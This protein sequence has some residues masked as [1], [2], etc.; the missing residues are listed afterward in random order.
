MFF[1][2]EHVI[3]AGKNGQLC[4]FMIQF[5]RQVSFLYRN[6][7]VAVTVDNQQ[8]SFQTCYGFRKIILSGVGEKA[9]VRPAWA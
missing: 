9:G 4:M 3:R 1:V 8:R 5:L 7:F 2:T 6:N